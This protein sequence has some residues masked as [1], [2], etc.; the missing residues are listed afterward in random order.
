VQKGYIRILL[1]VKDYATARTVVAQLMKNSS[2]DPEVAALNGIV[3]LN[4]G[5]ATEAVNALLAGA[6][7][8]PKDAFIQ[9]WLGKAALAKG[10]SALAEK[11]FRQAAALNPTALGAPEALAQIAAQRGDMNLL[12][13]VANKT[14]AAVPHFP[15]GYVWRAMVEMSHNSADKA[16]ADLKT[17]ISAA[18]QSPQAYLQLGKLRFAQKRFPEGVSLLEQALHYDPNSVEAMRLLINYD[19]YQK[20]PEKAL[21]RLNAQIAKSPNN[22]SF[23]D[24][25]AQLQIRDKKMDQAAATAQKA[26]Q[27]NSGDGEAVMLFAQIEVMRGQTANAVGVWEQWLNKHPNDANAIAILGTLEESRGDIGKA[28]AYYKKSLQIQPQQPLAANNLAYRMLQNGEN[29]DVALTFAQTARRAMPNSPTTAD[30]LAWAYYNKGAYGFA[31]GL[32]EDA[33][34]AEPNS[35]TMQY[36]L[37]M[38]YSKLRDKN[39]AA[40]HLKKAVSLAPDSPAAKDARAA[41]QD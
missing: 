12:A 7:N 27:L 35:A 16:E 5:K 30:T 10:D 2:K 28:E 32:L 25:L 18:P 8:F 6:K 29:V 3:L 39:N 41:L 19:L 38:V 26:I 23:Y 9:Y 13:D 21:D 17:A 20:Q 31:R 4:D 11:S 22:S 37:G 1:Q 40:I 24:F 34:K 33:V 36:H 14:I 15:G